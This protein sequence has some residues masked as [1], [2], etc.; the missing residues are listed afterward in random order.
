MT[1]QGDWKRAAKAGEAGLLVWEQEEERELQDEQPNVIP[2]PGES[3]PTVEAKDFA[4]KPGTNGTTGAVQ[5]EDAEPL[6][7]PN[8]AYKP[9]KILTVPIYPPPVTRVVRLE[10]VISLRITLNVIAEKLHGQ[11][12]AMT[13]HRELFAFFFARSGSNRGDA[14]AVGRGMPGSVSTIS[15]GQDGT[16]GNGLSGS[17]VNL[18][19][20][21]DVGIHQAE[22]SFLKRE[23]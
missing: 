14:A 4:D 9:A 10:Q 13:Q 11:T 5:S 1:A 23:S 19:L 20:D 2:N 21:S 16:Q 12:Y 7:F 18:N 15:F 6:L 22:P 3:E 8:G 17:F